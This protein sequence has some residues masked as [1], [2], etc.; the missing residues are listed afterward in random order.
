MD[1]NPKQT[2]H[3]AATFED[4]AKEIDASQDQTYYMLTIILPIRLI[5]INPLIKTHAIYKETIGATTSATKLITNAIKIN[6]NLKEK[7]SKLFNGNCTKMIKFINVFFLFY[8]NNEDNSHIKI[9]N[10]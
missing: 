5:G 6:G 1:N 2:E 8:M 7:V 3:L 4:I 9:P 10:K